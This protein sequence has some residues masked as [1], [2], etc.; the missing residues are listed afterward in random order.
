MRSLNVLSSIS[1]GGSIPDAAAIHEARKRRQAA[2]E[3]GDAGAGA[4]DYI[5]VEKDREEANKRDRSESDDEDEG[6]I[7]FTGVRS[8]VKDRQLRQQ[9]L[10]STLR[11][12]RTSSDEDD[13]A[14]DDWEE[15]QIRKAM[16]GIQ[17]DSSN[18][19]TNLFADSTYT[20]SRPRGNKSK[21]VAFNLQ[22]VRNHLKER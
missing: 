22:G 12:P 15:Q 7:S 11:R 6:R 16:G 21:L 13:R 8:D 2:R 14:P 1:V 10:H 19:Q 9:Q 20:E 18:N 17:V 4:R 3:R 5:P